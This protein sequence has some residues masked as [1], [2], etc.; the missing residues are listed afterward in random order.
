MKSEDVLDVL[1]SLS[2]AASDARS[3][4]RETVA[5]LERERPCYNWVGIYL[6][7]GDEL[8]LG[9]YVGKPTPHT[10]IPLNTGICGRAASSGKTIV[11]DV[12]D[13]EKNWSVEFQVLGRERLKTPL[14]EFSTIKVRTY[15][16]HEGVFMNKGVVFIWL[17]DDSRKVPVLM[18]ST[19]KVGSFVFTLT[20]MK[21]GDVLQ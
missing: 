5:L 2:S 19:L 16:R 6:L 18:K 9:P 8:V 1:R 12:L 20:D 4:M 21:P 17:T 15:P 7:E 14:G 11:V 10:R 3:L 13:S